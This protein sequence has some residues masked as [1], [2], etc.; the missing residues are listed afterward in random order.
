MLTFGDSGKDRL[1]AEILP[2]CQACKSLVD[3]FKKGVD[4]TS[5]YKFEGGDA[6]WEENKQGKYAESEVRLTEIQE[7]LC[8][9][10]IKGQ[11]QCHKLASENE[12]NFENWWFVEQKRYPELFDWLCIE[13]TKVCCPVNM[14]GPDCVPCPGGIEN[15]CN[16]NGRC[17]GGGTRKGT[18]ECRCN[19]GYTGKQC[20]ECS[21]GFYQ[22]LHNETGL[23]CKDCH[24]SCK[25]HCKDGTPETCESCSDGWLFH[26]GLGCQDIDECLSGDMSC[27]SFQF[28]VNTEGS[29]LCIGCHSSCSS[30]YGD[31]P[32]ECLQCKDS[33]TRR[34]NMCI[35]SAEWWRSVHVQ[36]GR[37]LTYLGL[38]VATFIIFKKSIFIASIVGV[39]VATYIGASEYIVAS[40]DETNN[41]ISFLP[42]ANA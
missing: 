12:E 11:L 13:T 18:G 42:A 31:A 27:P 19:R 22:E 38:C 6:T 34:G 28:C 5:R 39:A 26:T 21:V 17:R 29:H 32:D 1:K 36:W 41:G 16:G 7:E 10:V 2:D 3:S 15:P 14:F 23:L 9:D 8:K 30:C 24:R 37:H 40:E 35:D 4:R 20:E 33:Y 25:G